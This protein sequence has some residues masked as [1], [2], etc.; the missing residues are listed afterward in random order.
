MMMPTNE[1]A[2]SDDLYFP[3]LGRSGFV[4]AAAILGALTSALLSD[5][6]SW[7]TRIIIAVTGL[8]F[9][10][11]V[12]PALVEWLDITSLQMAGA[13]CYGCGVVGN[14][15][16]ISFLT[17]VRQHNIIDMVMDRVTLKKSDSD[18]DK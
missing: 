4:L 6:P 8:S 13:V 12:G 5:S 3:Q 15:I 7:R 14:L 1:D 16:V 9:S 11:F 2:M 17:W 10:V 18:K